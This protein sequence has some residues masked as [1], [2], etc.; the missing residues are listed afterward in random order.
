MTRDEFITEYYK[1]AVRAQQLLEKARRE[2]FI[3]LETAIDFEKADQRDILEYG[4]TFVVDG[5]DVSVIRKILSL[6]IEQEEDKYASLLMRLKLEAV[7]SIQYSENC[8]ILAYKLNAFTNL[9]LKDD[10]FIQKF[11]RN[12]DDEGTY[13]Q[14][15]INALLAALIVD[16]KK[17]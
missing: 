15:E 2:G 1:V 13:S 3:E 9:T 11:M 17:K 8:R 6:I 4:L 7:L 14:E 16:G 12:R 10:Q 5:Y